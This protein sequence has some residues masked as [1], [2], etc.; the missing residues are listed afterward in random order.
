VKHP[1]RLNRSLLSFVG[2]LIVALGAAGLCGSFGVFG[3]GFEHHTLLDNGPAH[4]VGRNGA[5]L[6]PVAA[7]VAVL[8]G[9][10]AL[11]WL[12]AQTSSERAGSLQ[13]RSAAGSG[14][15]TLRSTALTA[16]LEQQVGSYRG[17]T[18]V[19]AAMR[20]DRGSERL[21]LRVTV[22]D[23]VEFGALRTKIEHDAVGAAR[24]ALGDPELPVRVR[25]D[26]SL[27]T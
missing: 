3:S 9:L 11:R 27:T 24:A 13:I 19:K 21:A 7:F 6:W 2:V 10:A 23:R 12:A 15:T 8:L 17:V 14:T 4:F 5:W 22:A 26:V 25:Y 20:G 16:A 18:N 1:D